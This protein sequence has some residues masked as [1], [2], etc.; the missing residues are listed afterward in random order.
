M[1]LAPGTR[2]GPYEV[3]SRLGAGAMGE[4]Y[5]ARDAKLNR[6][7]AVK[8]MLGGST[9][10]AEQVARFEREAQT[11]AALNHANIAHIYGFEET[12]GGLALIMELVEGPTLA[13]RLTAGPVPIGEGMEL[14]RQMAD[15]LAYAH[16]RGVIHR[17]LKPGNVKLRADGTIKVL[18]FGLA[19]KIDGDAVNG[20]TMVTSLTMAGTIMGTPGYMAPE[21]LRGGHAGPRTDIFAFGVLL[22][23]LLTGHHPF[24][25]P[26]VFEI[27][28]AIL[29]PYPPSWP[30]DAPPV[31]G[32]VR[33]I[34]QRAMEKNAEARYQTVRDLRHDLGLAG[35]HSH[36][37]GL[38]APAD[39]SSLRAT[40]AAPSS[41][42]P[43]A[44]PGAA[45]TAAARPSATPSDAGA[46]ATRP[47]RTRWQRMPVIALGAAVL[48]A[49]VWLVWR[50]FGPSPAV[51][52][53]G[54]TRHSQITR[55]GNVRGVAFSPDGRMAA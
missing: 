51:V 27:G 16:E 47:A 39:E 21:L 52:P 28:E 44:V 29:N 50:P 11:L 38:P 37:V 43:A 45:E 54:D 53:A 12:A 42:V 5:R 19:K 25:R 41:Q 17:D 48:A 13:E 55:V 40:M 24:D 10:G 20:A 23:E 14:A 7:V 3:L 46:I 33:G 30:G 9:A 6:E 18:D 4:V 35:A 1:S 8:I 32:A 36:P 22:F 31:P 15:A 2:I 26:S 49:M 34:V